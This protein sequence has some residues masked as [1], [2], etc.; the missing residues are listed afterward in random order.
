DAAARLGTTQPRRTLV[1]T[2]T[3]SARPADPGLEALVTLLRFQGVAADPD[4][5][6][7]RLG[8]T[9]IGVPEMLRCAKGLGLKA[10]AH[11][12]NWSRLTKTPFP[13]IAAQRDGGFLVL[14][15]AGEDKVLLQSPQTQR[16]ALITRAEFTAVWDGRL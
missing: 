3:N 5:I 12:T 11:R 13:A 15:K 14:A 9:V 7:H 6:S 2:D 10:R 8:A 16:P 1:R 4:Q